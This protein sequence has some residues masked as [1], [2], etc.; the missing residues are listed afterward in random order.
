MDD[1]TKRRRKAYARAIRVGTKLGLLIFTAYLT[2]RILKIAIEVME[3]RA[4]TFGGEI[5][6]IPLITLLIWAGWTARKEYEDLKEGEEEDARN[7]YRISP[8]SEK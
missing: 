8:R 3:T 7:Q 5:C 1:R 4:G 2:V 6:I